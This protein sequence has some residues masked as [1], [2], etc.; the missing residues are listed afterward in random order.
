MK[1]KQSGALDVS[2]TLNWNYF[3][4]LDIHDILLFQKKN[5]KSKDIEKIISCL[6]ILF[7]FVTFL[8]V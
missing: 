2:R 4:L 8:C 6:V 5:K 1:V 3:L 7:C